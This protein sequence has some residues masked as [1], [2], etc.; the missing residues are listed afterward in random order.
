[1]NPYHVVMKKK[2]EAYIP[3]EKD[4]TPLYVKTHGNVCR[5]VTLG[6]AGAGG[7]ASR[8]L[9]KLSLEKYVVLGDEQPSQGGSERCLTQRGNTILTGKEVIAW[10]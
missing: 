7:G 4:K 8:T 9:K 6:M 2:E 10:I 1:M 5:P 3:L